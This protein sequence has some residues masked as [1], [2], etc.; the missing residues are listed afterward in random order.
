MGERSS[1]KV[2]LE[3][4]FR[5]QIKR[6]ANLLSVS[7][8]RILR[9][10]SLEYIKLKN[11]AKTAKEGKLS[12]GSILHTFISSMEARIANSLEENQKGITELKNDIQIIAAIIDN[13]IKLYLNHTKEIPIDER[14]ERIK[15]S[16][17]RYRK[18]L[19][20]V[21]STINNGS[22]DVIAEIKE[23]IYQELERGNI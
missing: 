8:S 12:E 5:E 7:M 14:N 21:K 13:F 23:L 4:D 17:N 6:E 15:S 11:E 1:T 16:L 3:G 19:T 10:Y 22:G 20:T 18:F 2:N 9:D